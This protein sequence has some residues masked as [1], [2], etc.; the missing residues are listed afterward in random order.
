MRKVSDYTERSKKVKEQCRDEKLLE[1]ARKEIYGDLCVSVKL[2]K[3]IVDDN[4]VEPQHRL[5]AATEHL[6]LAGMYSIKVEHTGIDAI[7]VF[8]P[9]QDGGSVG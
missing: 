8:L 2:I 4:K 3:S 5:K 6:K 1:E 7:Q 9:A